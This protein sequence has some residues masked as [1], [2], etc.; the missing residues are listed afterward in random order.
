MHPTTAKFLADDHAARLLHDAERERLARLARRTPDSW[1][2][3]LTRQPRK[4]SR[5]RTR[6]SEDCA[7]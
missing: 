1:L 4:L 6:H 5:W 3:A 7:W 2:R